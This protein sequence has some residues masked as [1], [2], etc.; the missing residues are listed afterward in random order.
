MGS[1]DKFPDFTSPELG[2]P[3]DLVLDSRKQNIKKL[4]EASSFYPL[5]L[6]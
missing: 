3:A 5:K 4:N 6:K 2:L 1:K